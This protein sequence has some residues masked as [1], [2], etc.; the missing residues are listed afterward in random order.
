[1]KNKTTEKTLFFS[2][3][4]VLQECLSYFNQDELAA[5]TW[6]K[7]YAM[8]DALGNYVEKSPADMHRRMAGNLPA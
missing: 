1:M 8:R 5:T 4:E 2:E 3:S 6:M 7:K